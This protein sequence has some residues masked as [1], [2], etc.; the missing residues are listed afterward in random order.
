MRRKTYFWAFFLMSTL[1]RSRC[2]SHFLNIK[3]QIT[4]NQ[5]IVNRFFHLESSSIGGPFFPVNV[6]P[7][8]TS[9]V[10]M[11]LISRA[12]MVHV[13]TCGADRGRMA[14]M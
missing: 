8:T 6:H 13:L 7:M 10:G 12:E 4:S 14:L 11:M 5:K 2:V 9:M 3:L 1:C